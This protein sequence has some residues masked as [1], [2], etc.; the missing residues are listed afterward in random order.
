MTLFLIRRLTYLIPVLIGASIV[1]FALTKIVPGDPVMMLAGVNATPEQREALTQRL[2]LDQPVPIQY[3]SWLSSAVL[4]DLGESIT[5]RVPVLPLVLDAFGNTVLLALYALVIAIPLGVVLGSVGAWWPRS[6]AGRIASAVTNISIG[7][8][9]YSLALFLIVFVA[10]P[11]GLFPV[12]GMSTASVAS[13]LNSGFLPALTA[14]LVP[15]GVLGRMCRSSMSDVLAMDFTEA[16]RARG[17]SDGRLFAHVLHNTSPSLITVAG[18]QAGYMLGGIVFVESIFNWPGLGYLLSQSISA[19][20][21][22]VIQAG[23]LLCAVVFVI[24]NVVVDMTHAII[25]PRVR[26][27]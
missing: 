7:L 19:R 12:Q 16:M 10:L 14:A 11:S 26:T 20:D 3:L 27:T 18:L 25:D 5:K 2:G 15:A 17:V 24:I 8:P 1:V 4:G 9:Q 22:P 21:L 13:F 6:I 23:V